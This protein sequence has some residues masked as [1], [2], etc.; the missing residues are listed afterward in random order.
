M[1]ELPMKDDYPK[2]TDE[3]KLYYL[4]RSAEMLAEKICK[5]KALQCDSCPLSGEGKY[6]CQKLAIYD[7]FCV[8]KN[9][10]QRRIIT[11][12]ERTLEWPGMPHR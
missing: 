8:A 3:E 2:R 9:Y 4:L 7:A 11:I 10:L 6:E 1:E 5:E 12:N